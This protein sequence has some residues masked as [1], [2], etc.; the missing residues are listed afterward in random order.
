MGTR[1]VGSDHRAAVS[2]TLRAMTVA[3]VRHVVQWI[4]VADRER[5]YRIQAERPGFITPT[6]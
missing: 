6:P 1:V 4:H 5:Q 3:T 2:A